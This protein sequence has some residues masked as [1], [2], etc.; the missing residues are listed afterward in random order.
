MTPHE[1]PVGR[2]ILIYADGSC[3]GNPGNGGYAAVLRRMDGPTEL[4]KTRLKGA[5]LATTNN[6][7]ELQA[8]IAALSFLRPDEQEPVHVVCDSQ[9]VIDGVTKY[10]DRWRASGWRKSSG[11][12]IENP[13]LWRQ[14]D[15]LATR[16]KTTWE[17]TRGHSGDPRNEEVDRLARKAASGPITLG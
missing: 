7:M 15:P 12:A 16:F 17:W 1:R 3:L 5:D 2:H 13:D 6:R 9:Y 11:K 8:V 14:L 4:R 10:L